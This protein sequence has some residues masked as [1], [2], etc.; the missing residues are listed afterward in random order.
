M[1]EEENERDELLERFRAELS[2]PLSER[3]YSEEELLSVF[4][5]AGDQSDNYIRLEALLLGM[6]LYPDS[7]EL[8][9]RRAIFYRDND[10]DT[11]QNFLKDNPSSSN[12]LM[13]IMRI[14]SLLDHPEEARAALDGF[15]KN[16]SLQEDEEVIQF[17]QAVHDLNLDA[18]L[19]KN[20]PA[21]RAKVSYLPTLLYEIAVWSDSSTEFSK[22][23]IDCLEEL[24]ELE[25]YT[26]AYWT[27]LSLVYARQGRPKDAIGAVDYA[28]AIDPDNIEA[29]KA[30]L[31]TMVIAKD[32]D[33]FDEILDH[34]LRLDP[35][36]GESAELRILRY[37]END[38]T[39]AA[40]KLFGRLGKGAR[41]N[42]SVFLKAIE[43]QY[44]DIDTMV[45]EQYDYGTNDKKDWDRFAEFAY[46][47]GNI[48]ALTVIRRLYAERTGESLD[49][50]FI[51][52]R[53]LYRLGKYREAIEAFTADGATGAL[54]DSNNLMMGYAIY[55]MCLLRVGE[56]EIAEG[57]ADTMLQMFDATPLMPGSKIEK[58]GMRC[59]LEDV[60]KRLHSMR[61]TKWDKYDPLG[62]DA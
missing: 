16:G 27:M 36:D 10:E 29:L 53:M 59:F 43:L 46:L 30:R 50:G 38:D 60:K 47:A 12:S 15:L 41:T 4:D 19:V 35:D 5:T 48:H 21:I 26:P 57:S 39:D 61:K 32:T 23:A 8:L 2:R 33:G 51:N 3:Y 20:L 49:D 17:V 34:V 58:Y 55:V 18:W 31:S 13:A 14:A 22:I 25:P 1:M 45:A 24:T 62:L 52:F 9:G 28:L 54:R 40:L 7:T 44:E 37:Q 42:R 11:F 6:R 56:Y